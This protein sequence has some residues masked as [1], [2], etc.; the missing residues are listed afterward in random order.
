MNWLMAAGSR[1]PTLLAG[2]VFTHRVSTEELA[3]PT[4]SR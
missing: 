2:R 1:L 3:R 4:R